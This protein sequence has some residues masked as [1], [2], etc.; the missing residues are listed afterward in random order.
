[1]RA[2]LD[3][4]YD[5]AL[6]YVDRQLGRLFERLRRWG[7][8]ER[9]LLVITADHGEGLLEHPGRFGHGG[10]WFDEVG[11][12]PLIVHLPRRVPAGRVGAFAEQIDVAPTMLALLG[13]ETPAGK[14]LD[15]VDLLSGAGAGGK[16][17][18][19]M[20]RGIRTAHYKALVS[21][22]ADILATDGDVTADAVQLFDL[23]D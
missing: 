18:A 19:L 11:R 2:Y 22:P 13:V 7:A 16:D 23:D 8:L 20:A 1:D 21:R 12:I 6:H 5:G 9:T 17:Q 15:G 3:A 4:L 14:R 10:N